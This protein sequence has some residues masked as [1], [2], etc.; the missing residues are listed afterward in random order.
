MEHQALTF[1]LKEFA[2]VLALG[3]GTFDAAR[4]KVKIAS[5]TPQEKANGV[6][7]LERLSQQ[8]AEKRDKLLGLARWLDTSQPDVAATS[9]SMTREGQ[10]AEG[11]V[12][13]D[14]FTTRLLSGGEK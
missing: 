10:N 6:S 4:D 14:E 12:G 7:V 11:Y 1:L 8:T 5:C 2:D 3:I 9:L 13:L